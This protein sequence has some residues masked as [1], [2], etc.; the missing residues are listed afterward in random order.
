MTDRK[1]AL[2]KKIKKVVK[3]TSREFKTYQINDSFD[4]LNPNIS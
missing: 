2:S 3:C 1:V 4:E